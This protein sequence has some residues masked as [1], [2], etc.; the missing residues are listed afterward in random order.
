M[1]M[2]IC[3]QLRSFKFITIVFFLGFVSKLS[4]QNSE[5]FEKYSKEYA[6]DVKV[7]LAK[8]TTIKIEIEKGELKITESSKEKDLYLNESV[9]F[10]SEASL[11]YSYFYELNKIEAS[12]FSFNKGKYK[13]I[14]VESFKEKD[15]LDDS[16]YDG[17]KTVSFI[18][19]NLK[20]GSISEL[21]YSYNIKNPRFL[22]PFY[23]GESFP[24]IKNKITYIVDK[25]VKLSFKRFNLNENKVKFSLKENRRTNEYTWE[26][27]NQNSFDF[28]SGSP[29]YKT[30]LPH[31]IPVINSYLKDNKKVNVLNDV[32]DL[33]NWYSSLVKDVNKEDVDSDLKNIVTEITKDKNTN[34]E[35]VKAIYYW[36]QKN[37]KYIAFEYALGGFVPRESNDVFKKKYGDCKDNSS[38]LYRMLE[39]AGLKGNLTWI[40][41]RSIPYT[42]EEVPTPVVD[43]HMILS[44]EDK[45]KT[46]FLDATGR[47]MALDLPTSFIQ[48]KE[49]LIA[50]GDTFKIRKVPVVKAEVNRTKDSTFIKL[51]GKKIIGNSSTII[52][53]YPKVDIFNSLERKNTESKLQDYYNRRLSKGNNKFLIKDI[54]EKNKYKYDEDFV[55]NYD[56]EI[57]NYSKTLG[58]EIYLNLNL[59]KT[60]SNFKL[61]KKRKNAIEYRYKV[62][63][64]YHTVFEIPTNY[65]IDYIPESVE[66]S[67][68]LI[69]C[70]I[71]YRVEGNQIIYD[72]DIKVNYILLNLEEQKRVNELIKKIEKNY[73]EVVVLKKQ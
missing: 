22:N 13:E 43:N 12:S 65:K 72:H 6:D 68:D 34:V 41:T 49:A 17:T 10:N 8:E 47:Y 71:K 24:I 61:D 69:Q 3:T 40:G 67:D 30:I 38:I 45:D 16:F 9:T 55:L 27:N 48:G 54:K 29:S 46:Y 37:I 14:E 25:D 42:Y 50:N 5:L 4:A 73:K 21:N 39:V 33:Y 1:L 28:E 36:V 35:K 18:Y 59:K 52:S 57:N 23:F 44:Y 32:S 53:G 11:S 63:Y 15:N 66:I 26:V 56:F 62:S 7:R 64:E 31:I 58:D 70:S 2:I 51:D 60:L 20:K 19:P